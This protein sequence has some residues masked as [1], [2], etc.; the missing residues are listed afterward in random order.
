MVEG[1]ENRQMLAANLLDNGS[2]EDSVISSNWALR[3]SIPGWTNETNNKFELQRGILGGAS[4]GA[5][6]LELASTGNSTIS[7]T[8]DTVPGDVYSLTFAFAGRPNTIEA[9]NA[10][11]IDVIDANT[12]EPLVRDLI[13]N[14]PNGWQSHQYVFVASGTSAKVAFSDVGINNG[15]GTFLDNVSLVAD[16]TIPAPAQ[17]PVPDN[18]LVNGSFEQLVVPGGWKLFNNIPGWTNE[19]NNKFELHRGILGGASDGAQH[20]ELA[21]SGN[22]TISQT[23]DTVPGDVYQLSFSFAG[24]PKTSPAENA[25]AI[26][27]ADSDTEE[28]LVRQLIST[29][30]NGWTAYDY[31]FVASG[32]SAKVLFSDVGIDNGVGTFLDNVS[33][34]RVDNPVFP[35][36][37]PVSDNLV[38]NGSFEHLMVGSKWQL[39]DA[40]PGW[41]NETNNKFE[42]HRG[43]L[44][45]AADGSQHAELASTGNSTIFQTVGTVPGEAYELTFSFAGRP[46]TSAVDNVLDVSVIDG[47]TDAVLTSDSLSTAPN[48]WEL[49]RYVFIATGAST[50][51][52]FA[53]TGIENGLGT[54]LDNVSLFGNAV[55]GPQ[56]EHDLPNIEVPLGSVMTT[57][58]LSHYFEDDVTADDDLTFEIMS[59]S[60]ATLVTPSVSGTSLSLAYDGTTTGSSEIRVR[61]TDTD[62]AST[63]ATIDVSVSDGLSSPVRVDVSLALDTGA[64][65]SDNITADPTL[66]FLPIGDLDSGNVTIEVDHDHDG[67]IDFAS[68]AIADGETSAYD[69]RTVD[70]LFGETFGLKNVSYRYTHSDASSGI[71]STS[72]WQTFD[73]ELY[74]LPTSTFAVTDFGLAND[75]GADDTDGTTSDATV[76]GTVAS[77]AGLTVEIDTDGDLVADELIVVED[78]GTF[79]YAPSD[80]L[81]YGDYTTSVRVREWSDVENTTL[82]SEWTTTDFTL[83]SDV[84]IDGPAS[85]ID[86]DTYTLTLDPHGLS[87]TEW[88]IDWGDGT[89]QTVNGMENDAAYEFPHVGYFDIAVTATDGDETYTANAM[90]V[91]VDH[92]PG[93][94]LICNG[95]FSEP[96]VTH[97]SGWDI[98]GEIPCWTLDSGPSFELQTYGQNDQ[99]LELDADVNGHDGPNPDDEQG[100]V[101]ISTEAVSVL[102]NRYYALLFTAE[103]RRQN[104][105]G[106]D[107]SVVTD[108]EVLVTI[109]GGT[110]VEIGGEEYESDDRTS[111]QFDASAV[112]P[113][114]ILLKTDGSGSFSVSFEDVSDKDDTFGPYLDDV[115]VVRRNHAPIY[116]EPYVEIEFQDDAE[117]IEAITENAPIHRSIADDPDGDPL[118][119]TFVADPPVAQVDARSGDVTLSPDVLLYDSHSISLQIHATDSYGDYDTQFVQIRVSK[120]N[121]KVPTFFGPKKAAVQV[122]L[123]NATNASESDR[124]NAVRAKVEAAMS[125]LIGNA[126]D[127]VSLLQSIQYNSGGA[128]GPNVYSANSVNGFAGFAIATHLD[129]SPLPADSQGNVYI[130]ASG[131]KIAVVLFYAFYD[132]DP[133]RR[134]VLKFSDGNRTLRIQGPSS[135]AEHESW[136]STGV[137]GSKYTEWQRRFGISVPGTKRKD[138]FRSAFFRAR[139]NVTNDVRCAKLTTP[140]SDDAQEA[141]DIVRASI[142]A[143]YISQDAMDKLYDA[144]SWHRNPQFITGGIE[145]EYDGEYTI[146]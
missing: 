112:Q 78:D 131:T 89:T 87:I 59:N 137:P 47:E 14:A 58:G 70:A 50:K 9:E 127:R 108:N 10:L 135:T 126:P 80:D 63:D 124:K 146:R 54:F 31:T 91:I 138:G 144:A 30:A 60:D 39:F 3:D 27:V 62:G 103:P 72:D 116:A 85:I 46:G 61:V 66:L 143:N 105:V 79:T 48:G 88:T 132:N 109:S 52:Q 128:N 18:L 1:L 97:N 118:T 104:E 110:I 16:D 125:T 43:I 113:G 93:E 55:I 73:F 26:D 2:F 115:F 25:L 96:E 41:T 56:V 120:C 7:Q 6:H 71:S 21:S 28:L 84:S 64:D 140:H 12:G 119:Y 75:T 123:T 101:T 86:G 44:G 19:T 141:I 13:S 69:P 77:G 51:I 129:A 142:E 40:I 17:N 111:Y 4:D 90:R 122:D 134:Q 23:V 65:T 136:H 83:A 114:E 130:D 117:I 102:P 22:S 81:D 5:Q 8:V 38:V 145:Y 99:R 68:D 95:D 34:E 139:S 98:F 24:R 45:G 76:T 37:N 106:D 49:Y 121:G 107:G 74:E 29:R 20:L 94:N 92:V 53:D 133:N 36:E 57:I 100:H 67:V 82:Y 33:L 42:L 11:D 32:T 35:I 15:L